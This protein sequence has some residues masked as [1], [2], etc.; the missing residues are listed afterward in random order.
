M[1]IEVLPPRVRGLRWLASVLINNRNPNGFPA[2]SSG[3]RAS[4]VRNVS[5]QTRIFLYGLLLGIVGGVLARAHVTPVAILCFGYAGWM[6]S[7]AKFR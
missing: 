6:M 4:W 2:S 7:A 5:R 3:L 1:S